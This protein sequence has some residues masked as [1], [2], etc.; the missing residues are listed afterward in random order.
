M[1]EGPLQRE[2]EVK[3]FLWTVSAI[4]LVDVVVRRLHKKGTVCSLKLA[5]GELLAWK[6]LGFDWLDLARVFSICTW[7]FPFN[8]SRWK[9]DRYAAHEDSCPPLT[10]MWW[11]DLFHDVKYVYNE[12][13]LNFVVLN[14]FTLKLLLF[15]S[16]YWIQV[17][18][19][20]SNLNWKFDECHS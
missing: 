15:L 10:T 8:F 9:W 18:E 17:K 14:F 2:P 4:F 12:L 6:N 1:E 20:N 11:M 16:H 7:Y 5:N 3:T 19:H 13:A